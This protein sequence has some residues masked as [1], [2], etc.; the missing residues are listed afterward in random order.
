MDA[1]ATS[2]E[3]DSLY[4]T[5]RFWHG[6]FLLAITL[7][8]VAILSSDL[9]LDAHV[10]SA[11]VETENGWALDWGDVRTQDPLASNPSDAKEV[12]ENSVTPGTV[13][14]FAIIGLLIAIITANRLGL[15]KES[16]T[17]LLMNPALIF[18]IGRGYS[19]YTYLAMIG[20]AWAIWKMSRNYNTKKT[21]L[22]RIIAIGFSAT[23][24]LWVLVLKWKIEPF[25]LTIPLL[26]LICVGML[27]DHAP[28]SWFNPKKTIVS[29]FV[30]GLLSIVTLGLLGH[31]SF[32][33]VTTNTSRFI[34]ALPISVFGVIIVYG[35]VG[36]VLWPFLKKTWC[37]MTTSEDRLT[38]ELA[39]F[40]GTMAG[41]IVA[42]VACLWTYES[43]LWNSEWPWH[44]WTMG[45][46][47]RYITIL[48]IPSY[49]L[50]KRVNGSIDWNERNA[51]FGV[52]LILPLSLAA[53]LHG[54]TYWTDDA[55][56]VLSENMEDG[57]GF[58]FIHDAA[59]GMHYLYTFHTHIENVD[60]RNI[61]G[62]WRSPDSGWESEL[63]SEEVTQ[64]RGDLSAVNWI[65]LSPG[66]EWSSPP[67]GWYHTTGQADFMNGGGEWQVWTKHSENLL[68]E[69]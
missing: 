43:I 61:T 64:N 6:L 30:F 49:L 39:L 53:G 31:G 27:I 48:V 67:E 46:N 17:V 59:L 56:E 51:I 66:I 3:S 35:V 58:V 68:S 13:M 16:V 7:N 19:E 23:L 29:G 50:I 28:D 55:A 5:E 8:L 2:A 21:P 63:F 11:Y 32:T 33:V 4:N 22:A 24:V 62:H 52:L 9:G 14:P 12:P 47:G 44:M 26:A 45:N 65:V 34:Q 18:S 57:E 60:E 25:T 42:Y 40:I 41:A 15:T 54:Q 36:M 37:N 1:S 38:G 69:T 10:E 20:I